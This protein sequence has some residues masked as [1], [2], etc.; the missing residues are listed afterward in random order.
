MSGERP[1]WPSE[2]STAVASS[3]M[4]VTPFD[5]NMFSGHGTFV[6]VKGAREVNRE[7]LFAS[8]DWGIGLGAFFFVGVLDTFTGVLNALA[9]ALVTLI[10]PRSRFLPS[11]LE[12]WRLGSQRWGSASSTIAMVT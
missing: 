6:H 12:I 3:T 2:K 1:G 5:W 10:G 9:W 4:G 8:L 11:D 7:P